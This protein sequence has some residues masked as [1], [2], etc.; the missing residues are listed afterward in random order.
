VD[1]GVQLP[2]GRARPR[3]LAAPGRT[4]FQ[5]VKVQPPSSRIAAVIRIGA[6]W[7]VWVTGGVGEER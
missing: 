7:P 2:G 6:H 3:P 4:Q 1:G 5:A